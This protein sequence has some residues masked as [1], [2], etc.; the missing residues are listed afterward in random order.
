MS[1]S[2]VASNT[3]GNVADT[4]NKFKQMKDD[5]QKLGQALQ[6]GDLSSAQQIFSSLQ[7]LLPNSSGSQTQNSSQGTLSNDVNA[8]GQALQSG[9][10]SQAQDAY[11]VLQK[12][13]QAA[14]KGHHHHR[15]KVDDSQNSGSSSTGSSGSNNAGGGVSLSNTTI[16]VTA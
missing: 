14:H 2:G 7:Q 10:L 6:S 13:M 1:I 9:D 4:Q 15:H 5:F 12:D 11:A 8:I 16:N 3:N